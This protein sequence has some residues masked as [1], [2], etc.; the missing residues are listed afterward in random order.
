M[1]GYHEHIDSAILSFFCCKLLGGFN[2]LEEPLESFR[3]RPHISPL[4]LECLRNFFQELGSIDPDPHASVLVT[5][6]P[7]G[8]LLLGKEAFRLKELCHR[9][10]HTSMAGA[11][12]TIVTMFD[13]LGNLFVGCL[14]L[15]ET[16]KSTSY[17]SIVL[18]KERHDLFFRPFSHRSTNLRL[19]RKHHAS[20]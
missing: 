18:L 20:L 7:I 12:T 3:S 4:S 15:V 17:G 5:D 1:F 10:T 9:C 13:V 2:R 6:A 19:Y 11:K 14:I 16:N 8:Y